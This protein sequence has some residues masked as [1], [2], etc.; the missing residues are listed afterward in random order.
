MLLEVSVNPG[1]H[2]YITFTSNV[3]KKKKKDYLVHCSIPAASVYI[4]MKKPNAAIRDATAAL[5]VV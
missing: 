5:E 3:F 1:S 4:R 2:L